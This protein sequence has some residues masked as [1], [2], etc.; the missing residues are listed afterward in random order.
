LLR[1]A[2][3]LFIVFAASCSPPGEDNGI[4]IPPVKCDAEWRGDTA[5]I[6]TIIRFEAIVDTILFPLKRFAGSGLRVSLICVPPDST[7][8]PD[9]NRLP[10]KDIYSVSANFLDIPATG[11]PFKAEIPP[12]YFRDFSCSRLAVAMIVVYHDVNENR[13]YDQGEPVVGAGEQS[14]YAFVQGDLNTVPPQYKFSTDGSNVMIRLDQ[15]TVP[16]FQSSPDYLA[17]IF[18]INV[19]GEQNRYNIPYP[20][21][22]STPLFP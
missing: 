22:V 2:A 3:A 17:T 16:Q 5:R 10:W 8:I 11:L 7:G 15:T 20:W 19:R 12:G 9:S 18:I 4:V 6:D 1:A 13:R 21:Y 14:L